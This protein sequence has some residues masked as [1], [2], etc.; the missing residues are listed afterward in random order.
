MQSSIVGNPRSIALHCATLS[1]NVAQCSA[2]ERGSPTMCNGL[3]GR[4]QNGAV[5]EGWGSLRGVGL[6]SRKRGSNIVFPYYYHL[7]DV[8]I[9]LIN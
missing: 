7:L 4:F 6:V 8:R 2:I 9:T 5:S 1:I 3:K